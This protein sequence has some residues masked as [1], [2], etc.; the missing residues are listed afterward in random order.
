MSIHQGNKQELLKD[1]VKRHISVSE[2]FKVVEQV[3]SMLENIQGKGM[4]IILSFD[5]IKVVDQ[6]LQFQIISEESVYESNTIKAFIK[7][8]TFSCVFAGSEDCKPVSDF[9]KFLDVTWQGRDFDSLRG[10]YT[11]GGASPVYQ[12]HQKSMPQ[13]ISGQLGN[14]G[15]TGVLDPAF[16]DTALRNTPSSRLTTSTIQPT[17]CPKL[18]HKAT[19]REVIIRTNNFWI[20][21]EGADLPINKDVISRKHAQLIKQGNNYFI[22]DNDSTNKTYVDGKQIPAKASVEIYN[23]TRI[24]FADEEYIFRIE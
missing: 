14:D 22:M 16:W 6:R 23:G 13:S 15:E 7:E 12:P 17:V 11:G 10:F 21:K 8:L 3:V 9:L 20:G 1:Y 5:K 19:N 2:Y 24:K 18:V 4:Q